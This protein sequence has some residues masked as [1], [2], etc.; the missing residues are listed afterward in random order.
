MKTFVKRYAKQIED[1]EYALE[2]SLSEV[3]DSQVDPLTLSV[4]PYEQTSLLHLI[5]TDN[6][7]FNKILLVF[8]SLCSEIQQL[9]EIVRSLKFILLYCRRLKSSMD[10]LN[11]LGKLSTL[12]T[13]KLQKEIHRFNL[14]ECFLSCLTS[15]N[16]LI[17]HT[18]S[19]RILCIS[20][21]LFTRASRNCLLASNQCICRQCLITWQS[22][23]QC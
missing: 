10:H 20:W 9:K 23:S 13:K 3:W 15:L 21:H 4:K 2:E 17:E 14:A 12:N 8:S 19:Q 18:V 6:K 7:V 16:L 22:Y 11:C 1:I 5:K